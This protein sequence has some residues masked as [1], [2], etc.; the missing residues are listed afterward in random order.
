MVPTSI[1]RQAN[2]DQTPSS[3]MAWRVHEFGPADV[4]GY[5]RVS[6]LG[7]ESGGPQPELQDQ[8]LP[9]N[10]HPRDAKEITTPAGQ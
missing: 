2:E 7:R 9:V 3:M 1:V 4:M 5:E 6:R 8:V 10:F